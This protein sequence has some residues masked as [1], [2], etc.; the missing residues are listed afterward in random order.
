MSGRGFG[1][2]FRWIGAQKGN[3]RPKGNI[4]LCMRLVQEGHQ[5]YTILEIE[6]AFRTGRAKYSGS[7]SW[8]NASD[9]EKDFGQTGDR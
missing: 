6:D 3:Q 2:V 8:R 5:G 1:M 9:V 7:G 4:K